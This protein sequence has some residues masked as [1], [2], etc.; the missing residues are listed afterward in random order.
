MFIKYGLRTYAL[1]I[2]FGSTYLHAQAPRLIQTSWGE[3][4]GTF[5]QG[6]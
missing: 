1:N 2:R 4:Y 5:L 6:F 3:T